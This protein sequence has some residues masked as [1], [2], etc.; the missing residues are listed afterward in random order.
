MNK[1]DI[2]QLIPQR[3]PFK[4]IDKLLNVDEETAM[5]LFAIQIDNC[6]LESDGMLAEAG[7]IE[8]IAQ[9]ASA[10]AGYQ[11]RKQGNRNIPVGYIGE[12]RNFHYD[13]SVHVGDV[14]Q[15]TVTRTD[16]FGNITC[17]DGETWVS[18][19]RIAKLQM[20]IYISP[21]D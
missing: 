15:T 16:V 17:I 2:E 14:L 20:K 4:M 21:N 1:Y 3:A 6:L 7:V 8:H 10:L 9:S 18:N 12:I 19:R 5:T 13:G 11:A